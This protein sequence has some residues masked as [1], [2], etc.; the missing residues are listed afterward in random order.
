MQIITANRLID[1]IVVY[2]T[3]QGTWEHDVSSALVCD[4]DDNQQSTLTRANIGV[5]NNQ[6]IDPYLI[7]VSVE[8]SV[9]TPLRLG[10]RIR[11]NGPSYSTLLTIESS[12]P[13]TSVAETTTLPGRKTDDSEHLA[14]L[15]VI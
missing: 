6:V 5:E 11:A 15:N 3:P 1:G 10:E 7:Q 4:D 8:N 2:F 9:I 12:N 13:Q 14:L